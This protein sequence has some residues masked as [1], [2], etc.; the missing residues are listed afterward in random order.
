MESWRFSQR[1]SASS[2]PQG[3]PFIPGDKNL[4]VIRLR[5]DQSYRKQWRLGF[6]LGIKT[7]VVASIKDKLGSKG[8][9]R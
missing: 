1:L 6:Q 3:V 9:I 4:A 5:I 7:S 8:L 2:T